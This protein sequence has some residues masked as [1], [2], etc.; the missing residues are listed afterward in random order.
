[1]NQNTKSILVILVIVV[2]AGAAVYYGATKRNI[3]SQTGETQVTTNTKDTEWAHGD[4]TYTVPR[5]DLWTVTDNTGDF[6]IARH[7]A[8]DISYLLQLNEVS[9]DAA[10][11]SDTKATMA[12]IEGV[13]LDRQQTYFD[14]DQEKMQLEL[15]VQVPMNDNFLQAK[16]LVQGTQEMVTEKVVADAKAEFTTFVAGI[17]KK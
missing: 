2:I 15:I 17:K 13:R 16:Y 9:A 6:W 5:G 11:T 1:M 7:R 12:G 8:T 14:G 3:V 10:V 4:V